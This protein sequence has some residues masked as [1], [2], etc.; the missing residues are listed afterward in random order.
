[1]KAVRYRIGMVTFADE[2]CPTWSSR[3]IQVLDHIARWTHGGWRIS[4]LNASAHV[5]LHASGF[6]LVLERPAVDE[7]RNEP[8][9][10]VGVPWRN[11]AA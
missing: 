11:R 4:R 10:K 6:C 7:K 1:M 3:S 9:R 8:G 2:P 5:R